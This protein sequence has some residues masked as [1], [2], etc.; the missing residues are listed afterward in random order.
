M[1][2]ADRAAHERAGRETAEAALAAAALAAILAV[3]PVRA[4]PACEIEGEPVQWAADVCMLELQTDDEIAASDCLAT[5]AKRRFADDCAARRHYK[6]R[7]CALSIRE[8]ARAG[9]LAA[10]VADPAFK[11]RTVAAGGVG[12]AP[13]GAPAR[14][15]RPV[16]E[17]A[18]QPDFFGFRARLQAAL[19]R[20]DAA[21]LRAVLHPGIKNSFGGDDGLAGFEAAWRPDDPASAVWE[22]LAGVLALG[23][24]FAPDGSFVAPYVFSR[25]PERVDAFTHLAVV[26]SAVRV[27]VAPRPDAHPLT[28]LDYGIVETASTQPQDEAWHAVR[29]PDGRAGFV[30]R[31]FVRSP[32][33]YRAAFARIGGRWQ[34]TLFLAGD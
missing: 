10:C 30:D 2:V 9:D 17:A 34:M 16:D 8:G 26:G 33:D 25:W 15:L 7:L 28:S 22:T 20:H 6:R 18:L 12:A 3:A 11:G 27:R 13:H 32:I 5:E 31:R 29:L 14:P 19:A 1:G 23:G 4:A 24:S 21:A